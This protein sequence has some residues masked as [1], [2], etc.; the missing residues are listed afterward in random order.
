MPGLNAA[1]LREEVLI[2]PDGT[3]AR[4]DGFDVTPGA[5]VTALVTEHGAVAATAEALGK[6]RG[7]I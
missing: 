3:L 4:N 5:L 1:G 6:L 2:T 7:L